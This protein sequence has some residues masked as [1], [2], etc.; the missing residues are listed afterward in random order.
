M[1]QFQPN[2][3][4]PSE[5][6]GRALIEQLI[7][8]T[9]LYDSSGAVEELFDFTVRFRVFAPFNAMLLHIQKPGITNAATAYDWRKKFGRYPKKDA[10]PLVIL[11]AMGP[12]DFVFDQQDTEGKE[13]PPQAF[14]FPTLGNLSRERF[15]EIENSVAKEK[16][17]ISAE[18]F[19]DGRAGYI[20]LMR[21]TPNEK[22]KN[23]YRLAYN[24]NHNPAT[25]CVT[26]A[27][28]LAHLYLGHLGADKARRVPNRANLEKPLKEVEAESAAYLVAMRNGLNPRSEKY[29]STYKDA[30]P[31]L[32]LYA[33]MRTANHVE[34]AMGIPAQMFWK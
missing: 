32:D 23:V 25:Q 5:Q 17:E 12:V 7:A 11:R 27:H 33:V 24:R 1:T 13:L 31:D 20:Q 14:A 8:A 22:T 10:R 19:G 3:P 28:E 4:I 26:V 16:I 18:D 9:K 34:S 15:L 29:L 21:K 2:T 6:D 30:L